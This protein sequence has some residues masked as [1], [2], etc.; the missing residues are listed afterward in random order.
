[1]Q[2]AQQKQ[3][4]DWAAES[5][6]QFKK[7]DIELANKTLGRFAD[8]EFIQLLADSG[9]GNHPKM[10]GLF[11]TIG[12]QIAEGKFVDSKG[13]KLGGKPLYSNSPGMYK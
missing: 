10:I 9:L 5:K 4:A 3:S 1:M 13:G 6:K 2:E 7:A 8:K 12:S 11:K